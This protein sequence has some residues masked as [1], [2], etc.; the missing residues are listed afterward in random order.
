M[1]STHTAQV[2]I[3]HA[4]LGAAPGKSFILVLLNK[5]LEGHKW[6]PSSQKDEPG[7]YITTRIKQVASFAELL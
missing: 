2:W 6:S 1:G 4:R 7:T 3:P 5:E